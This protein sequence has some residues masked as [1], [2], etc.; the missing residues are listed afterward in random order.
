MERVA[1][2][3]RKIK[4]IDNNDCSYLLQDL[5]KSQ[6]KIR[7]VGGKTKGVPKKELLAN[8]TRNH[9]CATE[10]AEDP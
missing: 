1:S 7:K 6:E 5:D 4:K 8:M 10:A 9:I 2:A 3:Y